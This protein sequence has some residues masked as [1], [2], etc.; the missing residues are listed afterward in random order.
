MRGLVRVEEGRTRRCVLVRQR[1]PRTIHD[2]RFVGVPAVSVHEMYE[3]RVQWRGSGRTP[4][5]CADCRTFSQLRLKFRSTQ[6]LPVRLANTHEEVSLT[7][8]T[9]CG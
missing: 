9:P 4:F 3:W 1:S 6:S 7:P 5:V 2:I 8:A